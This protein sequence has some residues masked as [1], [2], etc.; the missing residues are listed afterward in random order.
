M[1]I[2]NKVYKIQL[3]PTRLILLLSVFLLLSANWAYFEKL[4]NIYPWGT[5]N[6]PFIISM[7]IFLSAL[8]IILTSLFNLFF[9]V[10]IVASVFLIMAS[11]VGYYSDQLGVVIDKDMIR[12]IL[13]TNISEAADLINVSFLLRIL[14]LGLLPAIL[15]WKWQFKQ[16]SWFKELRYTLQTLGAAILILLLSAFS[17]SDYYASFFREHKPVRYYINPA[18]PVYAAYKYIKEVTKS[19]QQE[20]FISLV[21]YAK[22]SEGSE[23]S[24]D[25]ELIIVVVGETARADHF[26]LNGYPRN[27]NPNLS[28]EERLIS[29]S[30]VFSCG[31]STAIS[32]PCMF[33]RAKRDGFDVKRARNTENALDI[34]NKANVNVLWRDNNSSSKGVANRV[35]FED[36]RSDDMNTICNPECRDVGML[37]GLQEYINQQNGDILI[38]LHQMGSHGPAYYKRYPQEFEKFKPACR[39]LELASCSQEELINAYDNTILYTDYFLSKVIGLLK[40]NTPQFETT[41]LYVS[42]HGE[43][44]GESG[45]YLHG[46]PYVFAPEAQTRVPIIVWMGSTSDVDYEETLKLKHLENSHDSLFETLLNLFEVETDLDHS[47][48]QSFIYI[49]E[50]DQT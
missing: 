38:V 19:T 36:F 23:G 24:E 6:G 5:E 50:H 34:L 26:S 37:E 32:V 3:T 13:E 16:A 22:I 18:T 11:I 25:R 39:T 41:M 1:S 49:N 47:G 14:L 46:M 10:R 48:I 2:L 21:K 44:L 30:N 31:T 45:M 35:T 20:T 15:I 12:N 8:F 43:S 4:M 17:F 29:F 40:E 27:T 42:D 33:A 7:G 28:K 9:P